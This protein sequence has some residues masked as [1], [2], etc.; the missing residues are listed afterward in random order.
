MALVHKNLYEQDQFSQINTQVYFENLIK[1]I[2]TGYSLKGK[3]IKTAVHTNQ[4]HLNA[5]TLVPLALI[6]NELLTNTYKYA[7]NEK[8]HGNIIITLNRTAIGYE[9]NYS[10]DG[11]GFK[12]EGISKPGLG[13]QL[14]KGLAKQLEG[15]IEKIGGEDGT[16]YLLSFKGIN[17]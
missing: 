17:I 8:S 9:F 6:T 11:V 3:N 5:D 2:E 15:K 13:S 16:K 14:I 12:E 1:T 10:D 4:I 7:F